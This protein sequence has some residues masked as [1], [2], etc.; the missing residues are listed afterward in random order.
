MNCKSCD[1]GLRPEEEENEQCRECIC[2]E[3]EEDGIF[4]DKH[5]PSCDCNESPTLN[6]D[7][8]CNTCTCNDGGYKPKGC[9]CCNAQ[10]FC[11]ECTTEV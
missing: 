8:H 11:M 9:P 2:R 10:V 4:H 6:E 3:K 5:C 7:Q 1:N